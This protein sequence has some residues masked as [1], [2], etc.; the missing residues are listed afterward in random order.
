MVSHT[1]AKHASGE[2]G[3]AATEEVGKEDAVIVNGEQ[4]SGPHFSVT[5]SSSMKGL[6]VVK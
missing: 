3:T 4:R 1:T 5:R 6:R 2:K